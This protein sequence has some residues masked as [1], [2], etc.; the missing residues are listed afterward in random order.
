MANFIAKFIA[1][2]DEDEGLATWMIW[3][4]DS[5]N[6]RVGGVGVI[7][8]SLEGDIVE[9][10]CLQFPTTNNEAEYEAVLTGLNLAKATGASSVVIHYDL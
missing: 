1:K 2:K 10:I 9:Y 4:N 7:L 5:S 8:Q 3:T 6:Q